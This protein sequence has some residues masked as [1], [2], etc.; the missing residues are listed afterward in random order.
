MFLLK[1]F[2][3]RFILEMC[4]WEL[5]IFKVVGVDLI[6]GVIS[7]VMGWLFLEYYLIINLLIGF[8]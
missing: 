1:D 2:M 7:L 4:L 8:K 6:W 5:V 3:Y